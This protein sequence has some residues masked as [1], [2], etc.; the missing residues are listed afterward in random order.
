VRIF[1]P[2]DE[3]DG[4]DVMGRK[5]LAALIVLAVLALPPINPPPAEGAIDDDLKDG[6]IIGGAVTGALLVITFIA[7]LGTRDDDE[8]DFLTEAPRRRAD[9]GRIRFGFHPN[10]P[11]PPAAGNVSLVCW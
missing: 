8:P 1:V 11:C 3:P 4:G 10:R 5:M 2:A 9:D 7:I 6:L